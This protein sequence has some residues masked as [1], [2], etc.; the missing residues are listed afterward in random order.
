MTIF[1][2]AEDEWKVFLAHKKWA[3]SVLGDSFYVRFPIESIGTQEAQTY[4]RSLYQGD[5]SVHAWEASGVRQ[6]IIS[7]LIDSQDWTIRPWYGEL[8]FFAD[9]IRFLPPLPEHE[10]DFVVRTSLVS[11][12]SDIFSE[13]RLNLLSN[14]DPDLDQEDTGLY[15]RDINRPEDAAMRYGRCQI[16]LYGLLAVIQSKLFVLTDEE[17]LDVID[18]LF[19]VETADKF[20]VRRFILPNRDDNHPFIGEQND[21]AKLKQN[22]LKRYIG[23]ED[24][25]FYPHR[26][27]HLFLRQLLSFDVQAID[28]IEN[29]KFNLVKDFTDINDMKKVLLHAIR[30]SQ[31]VTL[32]DGFKAR[33]RTEYALQRTYNEYRSELIHLLKM[34]KEL[35]ANESEKFALSLIDKDIYR[36]QF[37]CLELGN[38]MIASLLKNLGK[39]VPEPEGVSKMQSRLILNRRI[40]NLEKSVL[41]DEVREEILE[42]AAQMHTKLG[43]ES[44]EQ[45]IEKAFKVPYEKIAPRGEYFFKEMEEEVKQNLMET[46]DLSLRKELMETT[47]TP[48]SL[49]KQYGN[50]ALNLVNDDAQISEVYSRILALKSTELVFGGG[51]LS[52]LQQQKVTDSFINEVFIPQFDFL[53]L[54]TKKPEEKSKEKEA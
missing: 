26:V 37:F 5:D 32:K 27:F 23:G 16:E 43:T 39:Q 36:P 15:L 49:A 53:K 47:D 3:S 41:T 22:F 18:F 38:A 30:L 12:D 29:E 6:K 21:H 35:F 34:Q 20:L 7:R 24:V 1:S 17:I 33:L 31:Y 44:V 11:D 40:S 4:K 42:T 8:A 28:R 54:L 46:G 9:Q 51:N 25:D 50:R 45:D 2:D 14:L 13:A 10:L 48:Q 19:D 52:I